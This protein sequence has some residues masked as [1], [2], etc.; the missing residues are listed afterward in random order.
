MS[1]QLGELLRDTIRHELTT[2]QALANWDAFIQ[3]IPDKLTSAHAYLATARDH[4]FS[5]EKA[6]ARGLRGGIFTAAMPELLVRRMRQQNRQDR[7]SQYSHL[8][9]DCWAPFEVL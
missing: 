9:H 8:W 1:D 6:F 2:E 5:S 4:T 3:A 7:A